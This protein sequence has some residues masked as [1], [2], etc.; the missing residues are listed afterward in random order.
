MAGGKIG[1]WEK[2]VDNIKEISKLTYVTLGVV[3]TPDNVGSCIE[4]I[5]FSHSLGVADIRIIPSAQWNE[6]LKGLEELEQE[7]LDAH[8]I[9]KYRVTRFINNGNVRGLL[10]GD[11][12]T[13]HLMM[14]DSIVAGDFHFPCVI[15][16]REGGKP[17][18]KVGE[19]MRNDRIE[20]LKSHDTHKDPICKKNCIDACVELNNKIEVFKSKKFICRDE[21]N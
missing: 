3:F 13:C 7:I 10:D 18:G 1:S 15:Y 12:K 17:I 8:P 9:L 21:R 14:D 19:N 2:V 5:R 4:T 20:Y 16:M 11:C 6:P